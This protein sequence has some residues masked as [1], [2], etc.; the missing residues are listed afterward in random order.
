MHG[1]YA[2][3]NKNIFGEDAKSLLPYTENTEIDIKLSRSYSEFLTK[4]KKFWSIITLLNM[5]EWA[6][7]HLTL[8]SL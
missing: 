4:A 3:K 8:L 5:I 7:N 6:K 2:K 1:E